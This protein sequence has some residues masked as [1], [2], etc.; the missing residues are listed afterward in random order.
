MV[1]QTVK[2]MFENVHSDWRDIL[3]PGEELCDRL[4]ST[5]QS[6]LETG[7]EVTPTWEDVLK[8]A[9]YPFGNTKVLIIGQ[10]PYPTKGVAHGLAFSTLGGKC[11]P[12]LRNVYKAMVHSGVVS[13]MPNIWHLERWCEQGII[14][15]NTAWTTAVGQ[16]DAHTRLWRDYVRDVLE[17]MS[18]NHPGL[19]V[20]LWGNKAK[21]FETLFDTGKH[22]IL[23]WTHPSPLA[24][25]RFQ[26]CPHFRICADELGIDWNPEKPVVAHVTKLDTR[27]TWYT[28]GSSP[29]NGRPGARA[30]WAFVN[31]GLDVYRSGE[32]Y[33]AQVRYMGESVAAPPTNIRGEGFAILNVLRYIR[34]NAL[35]GQHTVVT[36]SQFWMDMLQRYMPQWVKKRTHHW[37][38]HKN[39]DLCESLWTLWTAM[40]ERIRFH[41]IYSHTK[42]CPSDPDQAEM[43]YGNIEADQLAK[44]AAES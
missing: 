20:L 36:D 43:W 40:G 24:G 1:E 23:T 35:D 9:H 15:M 44:L 21:A 37:S 16:T 19:T 2:R 39:S 18:E 5:I 17:C 41:H 31:R 14:L 38:N 30:G 6:I 10:D 28:D 27:R 22:R 7:D 25:N 33:L 12:S 8:F 4:Y 3:T 26:E 32:V 42:T 11:P 34:D 29:G 13:S